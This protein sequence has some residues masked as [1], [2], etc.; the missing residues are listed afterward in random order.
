M[1]DIAGNH[2][3]AFSPQDVGPFHW[4]LMMLLLKV[5]FPFRP[6]SFPLELLNPVKLSIRSEL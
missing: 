2:F 6:H 1:L 5:A 3:E 4:H